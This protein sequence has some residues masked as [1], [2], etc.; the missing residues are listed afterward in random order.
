MREMTVEQ[1]AARLAAGVEPVVLLDVRRPEEN[2]AAALAGSV[3]IPLDELPARAGEIELPAGAQLVVYCH[4]GVRS[5][6][7]AT[8]LE[9][10]GFGE[11]VSLAGGI[12]AWS[13][14]ID[15]RVPRY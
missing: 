14:R 5:R 8:I 12:D 15:P 11:V 2:A 4:H 1:L 9:R 6:A 3:L 10:L 7:A 13:L